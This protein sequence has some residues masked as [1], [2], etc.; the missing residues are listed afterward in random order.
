MLHKKNHLCLIELKPKDETLMIAAF[1]HINFMHLAGNLIPWAT[2]AFLLETRFGSL[3]MAPLFLA[4]LLGAAFASAALDPPCSLV[5]HRFG[6]SLHVL[7]T[8]GTLLF[9]DHRL[10]SSAPWATPLAGI[11]APNCVQ[12]NEHLLGETPAVGLQE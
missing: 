4:T 9:K 5:R 3:R 2:V 10:A 1:L 8:S 12:F 6:C 7:P 11:N